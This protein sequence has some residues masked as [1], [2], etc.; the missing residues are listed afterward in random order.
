MFWSFHFYGLKSV[1]AFPGHATHVV[2]SKPFSR[3]YPVKNSWLW[4]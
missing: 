2:Q 1:I 3:T 4:R